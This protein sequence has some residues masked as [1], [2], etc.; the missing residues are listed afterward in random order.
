MVV[1]VH[2]TMIFVLIGAIFRDDPTDYLN[3][4]LA[5][6]E[7]RTVASDERCENEKAL[8]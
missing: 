4:E 1:Q 3:K 7:I 2:F 5:M 8:I 6:L